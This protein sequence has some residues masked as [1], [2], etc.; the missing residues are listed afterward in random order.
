[1]QSIYS[2]IE[3]IKNDQKRAALCI[4]VDTS[5]STP[6]KQG[7]KMIVMEDGVIWGT[8]GGGAIEK[9]VADKAV[10]LIRSGIPSKFSFNLEDDLSMQCGGT[11]EVYV[12]PLHPTQ[13]LFI[14]GAG[15][16]GRALAGLANELDFSVTLFDPREGI[17][18]DKIFTPFTCI[19]K[20]YFQAIDEAVFDDFTYIV[21]VTHKHL[22]DEEILEK[23][24]R[25]PHAYLGMIGSTR[26]VAEVKKRFLAKKLLTEKDLDKIDMPIG[27]RF[28]AESPQE[29]AVSIAA[30]LIDVRN[31]LNK[32]SV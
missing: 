29:I 1:M 9:E 31:T 24:A 6:R 11:V 15:H 27:I 3:E 21:I 18:S 13:K 19:N 17:F 20:D 2:R 12:E 22:F 28:L 7:A 26:K 14:F 16:I 25:K 8:I 32:G 23:V 5:G 4:V 30:K 10:E